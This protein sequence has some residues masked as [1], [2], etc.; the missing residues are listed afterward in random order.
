MKLLG[1]YNTQLQAFQYQQLLALY[2]KAIASGAYAGATIFNESLVNTLI[3][4][5]LDFSSL[6]IAS[7]GQTVTDD[8]LNYPLSLLTARYNA[9]VDESNSFTAKAEAL[10]SVLE[11]DTAL[12]D[13]LLAGAD[14]QSWTSQQTILEGAQSFSWDY[15]MGNGP[16]SGSITKVDP[17]NGVL[18]PTNC[19]VNTYIDVK[20]G[21]VLSGLVAPSLVLSVSPQDLLWNWIPMTTGEQAEALYGDAWAELDLLE[22]RPI[23]NFLPSPAVNVVLPTGGTINNIFSISGVTTTGSVP[24]YVQTS[25]VGRRNTTIL[26]PLNACPNPSF[27]FQETAWTFGSGWAALNDGNAH[28]GA[29]YAGKSPLATWSSGTT[30]HSG[31]AVNYLGYEYICLATNT[32]S[33]PNLPNTTN[34]ATTGLLQS[35]IFPLSPL[36]NVYIECWLKN[37]AANGIITIA[38]V[39]LDSN[40]NPLA[41]PITMP[42][43]TSAQDYIQLSSV[44]QALGSNVA[45]GLLQVSIF[46][47]TEGVW[48]IDDVRIHTPQNLSN[49]KV[50]QDDVAVYIPLIN[51]PMPSQIYFSDEDFIIDDISNVTFM[52]LPDGFPLT[53]RF[54]ENYPAYQCSVNE[55][56]WS[57]LIMLDPARPYPDNETMFNPIQLTVNAADQMTLFPITDEI[58]VPT[59]LTMEMIGQPLY[60][61]YFEVTTPAS[62]QYGATATL[63]VD[64]SNPTYLD[65][66]QIS[67][68]STYPMRLISVQTQSFGED[69]LQTVGNP[70]TL[71]DRPMVL[72]FPKTLLSKVF[73]TL[74]Q[75]SYN[76]SEYVVQPSDYIRRNA[77]FAIQSVLPYNVQRE[78][79][80]VPVYYRGAEYVFGVEDVASLAN[81]P[82]LP[83]VFIAGP[84]HFIGCPDIFR[85]DADY[86]DPESMGTAFDTYLCW[87]AYNSSDVI[88][89]QELSGIQIYPGSC[90]VF[91]FPSV[92]VLN[93]STVDHVD[94]FLKFVLRNSE[95]ILQRYLLQVLSV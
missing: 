83:G 8:S 64:I 4:Q 65:S 31:N 10:I 94:I 80:A 38:L 36:N 51:S 93:R 30:Y 16:S 26:T 15:G 19:P 81:T 84:H 78:Q 11:K 86:V 60:P 92:S 61:Y 72:T 47:Q 28:S 23:I 35:S 5:S 24:I 41:P 66:L 32:N 1:P 13:I 21:I 33:Q 44:L 54:T 89:S 34:W 71:L 9:I 59:G 76:L 58:G 2:Q 37:I 55:S 53:V 29:Y 75:E 85:Y 82:V 45:Y 46:G 77:L 67:P 17:N 49:Y 20:D 90:Q 18:Y 7:A 87:D 62:T 22:D 50:N 69:T 70:G 57:P 91:P 25:F 56:V 27:E 6:P 73:L 12:L 63:E 74:Y 39:C 52:D 3:Q 40:A 95:V 88:V 43:A 48:A 42:G 79:R 14:L 68:F